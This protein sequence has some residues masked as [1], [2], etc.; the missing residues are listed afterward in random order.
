MSRESKVTAAFQYL[1]LAFVSASI[2]AYELFVMR[3]FACAGWSH[4][5]SLVISIV[6]LGFGIFSTVFCIRKEFFQRRLFLWIEISLFLLGPLMVAGNSLA[7]Q[8]RFNPIFLIE[9]PNQK[10]L[11]GSY[12]LIYLI[13]FLFGA[14]FLGLIFFLKKEKFGTAYFANMAGSAIGGAAIFVS[15]YYL[16]P[17]RLLIVPILLW[18]FGSLLWLCGSG[19][20]KRAYGL[21][22][23]AAVLAVSGSFWF[24]QVKV[25]E[26]KAVSYARQFP[27]ARRESHRASPFGLLEIY[28]SSY[29]H[30][31]PGLSDNAHDVPRRD[32]EKYVYRHVH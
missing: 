10:Y 6:M 21:M 11:L 25:S 7:Q 18:I 29:F 24:D 26:F 13:P 22:A 20:G 5:G 2:L 15:M 31:A 4:F 9:D 12:F 23:L 17:E 1:A 28:S 30:F 8:V 19:A 16:V 32:T 27:D 14:M 3:V